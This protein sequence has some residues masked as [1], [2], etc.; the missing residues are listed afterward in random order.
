[1]AREGFVA[2]SS[3]DNDRLAVEA[4]RR[5]LDAAGSQL[6]VAQQERA[7]AAAALAPV[8]AAGPGQPARASE[9]SLTSPAGANGVGAPP[10]LGTPLALRAP[11][12]GVVLKVPQ[13]SEATVPAGAAVMTLGDPR[14]M[15]VLAQLLT[16][17][18][19]QARPGTAAVIEGW[20]GPPVAAKVRR[21]EPAAFT[22][23]SALGV[24]EQLVNVLLDIDQVPEAWQRM[25]DG[26]R[27]VVRVVTASADG[28]VLVPVGALFPRPEGGMAV[29]RIEEG[30]ARLQ[31]V[32]ISGRNARVGWV[33]SG[34]SAG[35]RVVVYPPAAVAEG[36]RVAE[37]K[38]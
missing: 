9:G 10:S 1:M 14:R 36:V 18:A 31:P 2:A 3:L 23:V 33:K 25:G 27:V 30:R 17:D 11:V 20:G 24:E 15:E 4:A 8:T 21:V 34:L 13:P 7:Q 6:E 32:D 22:K 26:F 38:P 37:R 28:V 16:T 29:Y 19:V 5:E 35:Q 12:D